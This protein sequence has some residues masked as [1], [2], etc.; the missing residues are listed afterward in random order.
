M[1]NALIKYLKEATEE[2]K[3][4]T[5]PTKNQLI[6]HTIVVVVMTAAIAVFFAILDYVFSNAIRI[7]I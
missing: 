7:L 2:S 5:W 3:K 4:V 6:N 1:A